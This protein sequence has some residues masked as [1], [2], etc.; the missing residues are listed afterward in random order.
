MELSSWFPISGMTWTR[1]P[2]AE[3]TP[4][5]ECYVHHVGGA[6]WMDKPAEQVFRD[7][8][9]LLKWIATRLK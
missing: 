8:P 3:K 5:A 7:N 2:A 9:A 4:D 1:P 6:A